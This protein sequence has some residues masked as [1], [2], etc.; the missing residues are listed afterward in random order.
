MDKD[1]LRAATSIDFERKYWL[2]V[3]GQVFLWDYD[4]S[5]YYNYSDYEKAQRRLTW[6]RFDNIVA[7]PFFMSQSLYCVNDSTVTGFIERKSDFGEPIA[8]RWKSKAFDFGKSNYL[9][10]IY[11][12]YPSIRTDTNS[13]IELSIIDETK[14]TVFN[15]EIESKAFS[16]GENNWADFTFNVFRF[17]KPIEIKSNLKKVIYLQLD[18]TNDKLYRDI[19]VSDIIIKYYVN[20]TIRR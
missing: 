6:Y 7:K 1:D 5:P 19:G 9:K 13:N 16:W 14:N 8:K 10:T 20:K 11:R 12:I 3:G 18:I 2:N 15:T 4:I 17:A